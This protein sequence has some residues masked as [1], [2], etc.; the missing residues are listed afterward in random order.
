MNRAAIPLEVASLS[1]GSTLVMVP[2]AAVAL[3]A[4]EVTGLLL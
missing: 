4:L 3:F 1:S 2:I